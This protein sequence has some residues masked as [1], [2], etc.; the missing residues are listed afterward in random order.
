MRKQRTLTWFWVALAAITLV[1]CAPKTNRPTQAVE[2]GIALAECQLSAPGIPLRLPALCGRLAVYENRAANSGRQIELNIAVIKAISRDPAPDPLFF[3]PGGPGEA[4]TESY[5]VLSSAFD[6]IHQKRDIVLVDQRGTGGSHRLDCQESDSQDAPAGSSE[7]ALQ[8][9]LTQCL[10]SLDAD[11]RFYTTSIAMDDLDQVRAAL[12]YAKINLYGASYGTRAALVYARQHPEQV[13]AIILD[14]VAPPNWTLGPS[15]PADAQRALESIFT[16]CQD[17]PDCNLAFPDLP[18]AFEGIQAKLSQEPVEVSLV[19]PITGERA[20][21]TLTQEIFANTL[22]NMS[23]NAETAALIPLYIYTSFSRDD[24]SLLAAQALSNQELLTRSIAGGMRFSVICTEDVPFYQTEPT[25]TGY[26][27]DSVKNSLSQV[28]KVWPSGELPANFKDPVQTNTP[29]LLLSGE[30]DP[31]TPPENASLTA[32][33]L[34]NSLLIV[35][36]GQGHITI[37]RGCIPRLATNFIDSGSVNGLDSTCV[38]NIKPLP[39]FVNY[40]GPKP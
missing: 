25:T 20:K 1:A 35:A 13:R 7:Q 14:G 10:A 21:F 16:R 8:Q 38:E 26:L 33:T 4:A 17:D 15:A 9:S 3:I 6:R 36:P 11:P 19:H 37:F 40:S 34:P 29:V 30:Y 27:G 18:K 28:C 23:Y 39:F 32:Q 2:P 24:Y 31:V 22:H 5:L 12:G